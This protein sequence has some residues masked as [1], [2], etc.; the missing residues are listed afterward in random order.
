[1]VGQ[2]IDLKVYFIL[3]CCDDQLPTKREDESRKK[4][5][6][7]F[8]RAFPYLCEFDKRKLLTIKLSVFDRLKLGKNYSFQNSE[9]EGV[10]WYDI[11]VDVLPLLLTLIRLQPDTSLEEVM[12][13]YVSEVD[14]GNLLPMDDSCVAIHWDKI[15]KLIEDKSI[16]DFMSQFG[17]QNVHGDITYIDLVDNF[18]DEIK[19]TG[20]SSRS[21]HQLFKCFGESTVEIGYNSYDV[22][23]E[24]RN[25]ENAWK[26]AIKDHMKIYQMDNSLNEYILNEMVFP[27]LNFV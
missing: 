4:Q 27:K 17:R 23:N 3:K 2:I 9:A 10:E 22:F 8:R 15:F 16:E 6:Y 11:K 13:L 5:M 20:L 18:Y 21:Y 1:M 26:S 14:N 12:Q 24:C 25:G 19:L 7:S